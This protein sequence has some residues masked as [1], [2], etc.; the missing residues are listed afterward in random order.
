MVSG[1]R[2]SQTRFMF[3][4]LPTPCGRM[5]DILTF[6]GLAQNSTDLDFAELRRDGQKVFSG[7]NYVFRMSGAGDDR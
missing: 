2:C 4:R 3:L 5:I 1:G 7:H 6:P